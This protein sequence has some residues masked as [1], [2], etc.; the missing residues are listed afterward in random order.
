MSKKTPKKSLK[1]TFKDE[2]KS[3]QNPVRVIMHVKAQ[4]AENISKYSM[5]QIQA[6][7]DLRVM[8]AK[9][10]DMSRV[11]LNYRAKFIAVKVDTPKFENKVS[12]AAE[13]IDRL[14]ADKGYDKVFQGDNIIFHIPL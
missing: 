8:A 4:D 9:A 11:Y 2:I 12:Q 10:Y 5:D 7:E 14:C 6:G 1:V 13:L 3:I